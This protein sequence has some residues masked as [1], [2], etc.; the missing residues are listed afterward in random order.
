MVIT[1]LTD[2]VP[3][4]EHINP[5][6]P[7]HG[8]LFGDEEGPWKTE[9]Q[10][11][12]F[13]RETSLRLGFRMTTQDYRHIATAIDRKFIRP[14]HHHEEE[15]YTEDEDEPN[16]V[17]AGHGSRVANAVYGRDMDQLD[18]LSA[19][20][21]TVF[22]KISDRWQRWLGLVPRLSRD[23]ERTVDDDFVEEV[24]TTR[25]RVREKMKG[26]F[27]SDYK[28]HSKEQEEGVMAVL[29]GISPISIIPSFD[30]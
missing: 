13:I 19:R 9:R 15:D 23:E 5:D 16:D 4:R 24:N 8:F 22:R 1:Y 14:N 7:Q 11:K 21:I 2:V 18:R 12:V 6:A 28:F 26:L 20:S 27:G 30:P 25:D 29:D 17:M 10:T 3:F